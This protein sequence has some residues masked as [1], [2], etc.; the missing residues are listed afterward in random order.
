MESLP[1]K[2]YAQRSGSYQ[3]QSGITLAKDKS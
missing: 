2:L 1:R 3:G